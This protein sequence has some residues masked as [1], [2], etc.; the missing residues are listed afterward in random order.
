MVLG[1]DWL[2][3]LSESFLDPRVM[4]ARGAILP[5]WISGRP[6]WFPE[7]FNW[8][9]GCTYR[10]LSEHRD[11]VRNLIGCNMSF[12]KDILMANGGFRSGMGRFGT[13]PFG[14]E[15][16]ELCIRAADQYP[17]RIFISNPAAKVLHRVTPMRTKFGY[18]KSR[19]Y[20][21][22]LSK[23]LVTRYVG[24]HNGLRSERA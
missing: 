19:C 3:I 21:E 4:G 7:E 11:T 24:Y 10:G 18:F 16:T 13:I 14:C 17:D 8:V 2:E 20:A 22:G 12:Y 23:A 5:D 6:T 1:S 9:V 15:E